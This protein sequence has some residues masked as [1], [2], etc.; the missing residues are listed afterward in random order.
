MGDDLNRWVEAKLK[1]YGWS[2]RELARRG[3]LSNS[4]ISQVLSGRAQPGA[5][6]YQGMAKA[7]DLPISVIELLDREGTIPTNE[8][9]EPF[10]FSEWVAILEQ[11]TPSER[12]ELVKLAFRLLLSRRIPGEDS[13]V[14]GEAGTAQPATG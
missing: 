3:G 6:F 7:F 10:T 1:D 2:I 13:D 8:D 11:L 9:D 14:S 5:K 12:A 4:Y